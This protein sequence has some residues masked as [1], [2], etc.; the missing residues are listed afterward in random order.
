LAVISAVAF[1]TILALLAGKGFNIQ[2]LVGPA[3]GPA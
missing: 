2:F 3:P 1:A